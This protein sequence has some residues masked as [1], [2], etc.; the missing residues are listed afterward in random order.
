[1]SGAGPGS[2]RR[3]DAVLLLDKPAGMSSHAAVRRA[4]RLYRARKAGHTGTLDPAATGLLP[5]CFG[6]ATK[7]AQA[8]IGADKTYEATIALGLTTTTG[9]LEGEVTSERPVSASRAE[10]ERVLE[11]F[12]GEIVQ[13]PPMYSALKHG[14]RPLYRIA[15]AGGEVPRAARTVVIHRLVLTGWE[16]SRF[17]VSVRCSKGTYIRVLAEDIGRALGCGAALAALRRTAVGPFGVRAAATFDA[18]EAMHPEQR[19]AR[20]LPADALLEGL[21][22]C[23]LDAARALRL[24][25]GQPVEVPESGTPGLARVYGPGP[26]FLGLAE[27]VAPGRLAPRRLL[28]RVEDEGGGGGIG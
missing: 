18:L 13:V 8:L 14:G 15:R 17:T 26:E 10:V 20:L 12:V 2:R 19:E 22:R 24:R 6:E 27:W 7:F 25:S 11:R 9:D 4:Q 21:P 16:G 1:M 23:D 28:A 5:V 3:L